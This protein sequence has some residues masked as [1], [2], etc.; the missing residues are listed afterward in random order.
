MGLRLRI[1]LSLTVRAAASTTL[2]CATAYWTTE[3]RL[4]QEVDRAIDDV[5]KLLVRNERPGIRPGNG[6]GNDNPS[7]LFG[8]VGTLYREFESRSRQLV[9]ATQFLDSSGNVVVSPLSEFSTR[10]LPVDAKDKQNWAVKDDVRNLLV[11]DKGSTIESWNARGGI[12]ILHVPRDSAR[13][14]DEIRQKL[15]L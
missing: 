10:T 1:V 8:A 6:G 14:I 9:Y 5:Q 2:A 13:S 4:Y 15:G 3:S 11:D 7:S 12:G